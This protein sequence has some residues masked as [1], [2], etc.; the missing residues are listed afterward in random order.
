MSLN[1]LFFQK[2]KIRFILI[3]FFAVF[4]SHSLLAQSSYPAKSIKFIVPYAPGGGTDTFARLTAQ[5]L[6]KVI[7]QNVVV[8]NVTGAAG[9]VA[10]SQVARSVPDGYTILVEQA[11]IATNPLLYDKVP[12]DVKKD[13]EP[14]ILGVNL[15]NVLVVSQN[16]PAKNV[17]ELIA[18]AKSQPGKLNYASTGIG[19]PQH[20]A[21][22]IFKDKTGTLIA[23]IPYKGGS[24]G[25]VATVSN[26]VQMFLISVSTAL[27]FIKSG[28]VKA[29][30]NGGLK[31]SP[32]LP[33]V[34]AIAE[35][36]PGF[37]STN[38]L[39]L[40]APAGTPKSV[41]QTLNENLQK[42]YANPE[43]IEKFKQQGRV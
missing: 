9:M 27:P 35:S 30:G 32:L 29:L 24:P 37:Q 17:I 20:L 22:E 6:S 41:I 10:G 26:E 18:L 15:D 39:A 33:D 2:P 4:F 25:M 23:H 31:R 36:L 7:G 8:D 40:F 5:E 43:L 3:C 21:M 12:F 16:T 1:N 14:V 34:P 38:W 11:S 28:K 13:L 42:A 19:S